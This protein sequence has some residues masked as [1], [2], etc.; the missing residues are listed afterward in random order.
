[1]TKKTKRGLLN[2]LREKNP[3]GPK[4]LLFH[5][6]FGI[7]SLAAVDPALVLLPVYRRRAID[8]RSLHKELHEHARST[9][10]AACKGGS[11]PTRAT[12]K[13]V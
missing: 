7:L 4:S 2:S 5:S 8:R 3:C 13:L 12:N 6:I 11:R 1:M 9:C 10:H